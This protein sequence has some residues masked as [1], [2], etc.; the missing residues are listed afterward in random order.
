M[1]KNLFFDLDDTLWAFS[2]NSRA[3]FEAMYHR[4]HYERFFRSFAHFYELYEYRNVQLWEAYGAGDIT[5]EELNR[6]RFLYPLQ[7]VGAEDTALAETFAEHFF[8]EVPMQSGLMPHAREVLEYLAPRYNLYILSN[9]FQELQRRKMESA[10]IYRYFKKMVLS[11]DIGVLKPRP[12]IFHFA[13]SA[14]QSQLK[15]S[16]MIGDN[17]VNDV[18]GAHGVGMHQAFYAPE[19]VSEPLPFAPTYLITDLRELTKL[20]AK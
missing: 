10:D 20:L 8:A 11:D 1:Y 18:E 7:A 6:Q 17:W 4:F 15:D 3:T 19:G 12:E 2:A 16:L 9:G 14:T 13:L 5:K